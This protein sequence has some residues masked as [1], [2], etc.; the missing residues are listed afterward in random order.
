MTGL[1][2]GSYKA[3][4]DG[5]NGP[6]TVSVTVTDG[7]L[8][9]VT[10]VSNNETEN[11]AGPALEKVPAAMVAGNTPDVDGVTGATLTSG[12]IMDAVIQCLD[13]AK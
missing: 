8:A 13:Q 12:R 7:K 10:I 2:D 5:Q 6:M 1:K 9:E 4:V 3:T 11:I